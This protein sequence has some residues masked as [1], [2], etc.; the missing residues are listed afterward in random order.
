MAM[1]VAA[2]LSPDAQVSIDFIVLAVA[3][4]RSSLAGDARRAVRLRNV[5]YFVSIV[6]S[7]VGVIV[8]TTFIVEYAIPYNERY[9]RWTS[10]DSDHHV[11]H[12]KWSDI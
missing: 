11:Q 4:R 12:Y 9:K 1:A 7:L 5:S 8:I 10:A 3:G 2:L 6:G